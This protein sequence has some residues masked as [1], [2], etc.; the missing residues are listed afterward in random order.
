ML[1]QSIDAMLDKISETFFQN[2]RRPRATGGVIR[3]IAEH[4][5]EV[6][7][8]FERVEQNLLLIG[9]WY[10]AKLY[11]AIQSEL[12]LKDWKENLKNKLDNLENIVQ[13][14]KDNFSLSLET[15][16]ARVEM[17]AW[18]LM[19]IGYMYLTFVDLGLIKK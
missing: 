1:D 17:L 18:A 4:K 3:Q 15:V 13:T 9:D 12:Y 19:L 11:E 10:T 5:L 2:K 16:W 7:L 8:D 14:I 6:M